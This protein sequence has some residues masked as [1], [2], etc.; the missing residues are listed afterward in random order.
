MAE[1]EDDSKHCQPEDSQQPEEMYAGQ[2][3]KWAWVES[4]SRPVGRQ[5]EPGKHASSRFDVSSCCY[6]KTKQM[7][8]IVGW[9][10][11][12]VEHGLSIA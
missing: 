7:Y 4:F 11:A 5:P 3:D 6:S 2:G 1:Q 10:Q 9:A 8:D 12:S